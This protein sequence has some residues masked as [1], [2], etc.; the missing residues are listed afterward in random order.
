M[1]LSSDWHKI[2]FIC[3]L[4]VYYDTAPGYFIRAVLLELYIAS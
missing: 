2:M 3:E 4:L 1:Y